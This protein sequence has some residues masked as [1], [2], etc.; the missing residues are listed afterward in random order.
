MGRKR[1]RREEMLF[2]RTAVR[3]AKIQ[4]K[5]YE[6]DYE[7]EEDG[8]GAV[9][10]AKEMGQSHSSSDL[11]D[12]HGKRRIIDVRVEKKGDQQCAEDKRFPR[13]A[14]KRRRCEF[15]S[16]RLATLPA[17][18]AAS[19]LPSTCACSEKKRER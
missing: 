6:D 18:A 3:N 8:D 11:R 15:W 19:S 2:A 1:S 16:R 9:S 7:D 14:D 10:F 12:F 13:P 5:D 4:I 17:A